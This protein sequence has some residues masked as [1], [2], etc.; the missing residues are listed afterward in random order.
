G[1]FRNVILGRRHI[2]H[3]VPGIVLA[4]AAGGVAIVSRSENIEPKLALLFGAGLGMTLDES[5]LLLELDDVYWTPEG[6]LSVEIA[7]SVTAALGGLAVALRF[8]RRGERAVLDYAD[9]LAAA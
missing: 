4:F 3:F 8:F 1:P 2:H 9:A 7:L 6:L 5:A